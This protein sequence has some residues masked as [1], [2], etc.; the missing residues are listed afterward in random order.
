MAVARLTVGGFR[1]SLVVVTLILKGTGLVSTYLVF[2]SDVTVVRATVFVI[3]TDVIILTL[4]TVSVTG[5]ECTSLT[6]CVTV[7]S[8][9]LTRNID[10]TAVSNETIASSLT[11]FFL[12]SLG[13]IQVTVVG[14][15][16]SISRTLSVLLTFVVRRTG[17]KHISLGVVVTAFRMT[18]FVDQVRAVVFTLGPLKVTRFVRTEFGTVDIT[19]FRLTLSVG[20]TG[21]LVGIV[22]SLFTRYHLTSLGVFNVTVTRTTVFVSETR[23]SILTLEAISVT[24]LVGADLGINT[25][26]PVI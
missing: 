18:V 15:T 4:E 2:T 1:T 9:T 10:T 6:D 26:I 7:V 8:I 19:V 14:L 3:E 22:T 24:G 17:L 20:I 25:S 11:R 16:V 12:T 23:A 13:A 5:L 21:V